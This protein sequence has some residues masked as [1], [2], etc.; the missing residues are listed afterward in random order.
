MVLKQNSEKIQQNTL[1]HTEI[2]EPEISENLNGN[3][4]QHFWNGV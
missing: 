3:H 1:P 4:F 2:C